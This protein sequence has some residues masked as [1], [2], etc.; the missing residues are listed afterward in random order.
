MEPFR[1]A[2]KDV[3]NQIENEKSERIA[4]EA[5]NESLKRQLATY[6]S[7]IIEMEKKKLAGKDEDDDAQSSIS[8]STM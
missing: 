3:I 6:K 8:P 1:N 5:E 4:L 2:A 7:H